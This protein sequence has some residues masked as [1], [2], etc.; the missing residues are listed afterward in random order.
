MTNTA[1]HINTNNIAIPEKMPAGLPTE[2]RGLARDEVKLMVSRRAD[3]QLSHHRFYELPGLLQ[4]GDVL[5]VNTSATLPA[6]LPV[7]LPDGRT[8]RMHLSSRINATEWWVEI[9]QV[10]KDSTIRLHEPQS[11]R[12]YHLPEGG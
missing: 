6:A 2:R 3:N 7:H 9:R 4:E 8:A 10:E 5:V 12:M 1:N 11:G